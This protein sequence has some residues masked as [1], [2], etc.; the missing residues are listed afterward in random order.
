LIAATADLELFLREGCLLR[1]AGD[2]A[3]T[4]VQRRGDP[5]PVALPDSDA[6]KKIASEGRTY[7]DEQW[8]ADLK[9]DNKPLLEH[10][11]DL[12]KAK[13]LLAKMDDDAPAGD[14]G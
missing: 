9:R 12:K 5:A 2:D 6:L 4:V 11:F 8:P 7:F 10:D 14:Q 3:W 1:Y 13:E